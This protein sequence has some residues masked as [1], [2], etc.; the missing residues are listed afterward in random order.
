M[1]KAAIWILVAWTAMTIFPARASDDFNRAIAYYLAGDMEL[2]KKNLDAHF[3]SRHQPTVQLGFTLLF[4]GEKWEATKKFSDYLESNHRSLESLVGI[5]LATA[6]VK[7]SLASDNLNKVLRMDPGFA[8]AYACLGQEHFLRDDFPAAEENFN[9]SLRYANIPEY[10][11]LLGKLLLKTGR[12][13]QAYD[14]IRPLAESTPKNFHYAFLAAR[15]GLALGDLGTAS[16]FS[17]Q[18]QSARPDAKEAQLLHGQLLLASGDLRRAKSLLGKL[19][20]AYYNPEY[21]LTLAEVLV[22]LKDRDA[23][24]YLYE[25]FSQAPWHPGIN[26]LLG[27]F[28]LK[29]K[30]ANIQNWIRRALLSGLPAQELQQEFP[31]QYRY[32][33]RPSF[34]IFAARMIQWLGNG[35]LAVA[36]AL[37]SGEKEKLTILDAATLKPIQSFAYEG[38]IQE[39]FAAPRRDKFIFSSRA[40]G[41]EKVYLYTL[42]EERNGYRLKPVVGYALDM[43]RVQ[44]A[45]NAGGTM[46]FVTDGSLNDLAFLSPFSTVG[47]LGRRQSIYPDHPLTVFSYSYAGERWT[48]VRNREA[49]RNVP[50]PVVRRYYAV[51]D[52]CRNHAEVAKLLEKGAA[53]DITSSEEMKIL[54]GDGADHFLICF[55]DLKNAFQA[56]AYDAGRNRLTRFDESMFLGEKYYADLD[57]VAFHPEKNEVLVLTRDKQ[58]NLYHFNYRSLLYK[59]IAGSALKVAVTP[60]GNTIYLLAER[61]QSFYFSETTLEIVQLSPFARRKV[62]SR[63]DLEDINDCSDANAVYF[64]TFNGELLKLDDEGKFAS[65]QVSLAGALHQVSPD[66]KKAAAFI[67]NRIHVLDWQD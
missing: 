13:Q 26:K 45:F 61:N 42:I 9:Q 38:S 14:L 32:P 5:S 8:P 66:K 6:D 53:L 48:Q 62:N 64:T 27:L 65:R 1:K 59:K 15:A 46:A 43:A 30:K 24:K 22:R 19:K 35:R 63:R 28:H 20:F 40:P 60:D 49:L 33:E 34:A 57:V 31:A 51:A 58:R 3:S 16:R 21:S 25:V 39:I 18:A 44:V 10:K 17:E 56:W 37:R 29:D 23:E 36:G 41:N 67:N 54:F 47:S 50:L 4:Q 11:I 12:L 2:A 7:N 55:S 52:A